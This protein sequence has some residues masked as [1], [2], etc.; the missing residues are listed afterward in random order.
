M[1][2]SV[3]G[4]RRQHVSDCLRRLL[5][6]CHSLKKRFVSGKDDKVLGRNH[7]P[8]TEDLCLIL[9]GC[10]EKGLVVVSWWDP[11]TDM[12]MFLNLEMKTTSWNI[13]PY[14]KVLNCQTGSVEEKELQR[15]EDAGAGAV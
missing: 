7:P 2:T 3:T 11:E 12:V 9:C 15:K 6:G 1:P 8:I 4:L 13:I 5:R 14:R 10:S